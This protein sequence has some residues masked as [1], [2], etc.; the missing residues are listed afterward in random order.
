MAE[1]NHNGPQ[2]L[3]STAAAHFLTAI[4]IG[5]LC[6]SRCRTWMSG[7][8]QERNAK[9]NEKRPSQHPLSGTRFEYRCRLGR[10]PS[11]PGECGPGWP[12][13]AQASTGLG[14]Q[15]SGEW[16]Q[17]RQG[18]SRLS[19]AVCTCLP[20]GPVRIW[21]SDGSR[22]RIGRLCVESRW[23]EAHVRN[24]TEYSQEDN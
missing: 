9:S 17:G 1:H 7:R 4:R 11:V 16:N 18:L 20:G 13:N 8:G 24:T 23:A 14:D 5:K 21:T 15:V 19:R 2:L 10:P 3:D 6:D 12:A 22:L